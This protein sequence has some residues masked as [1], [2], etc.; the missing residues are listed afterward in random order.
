M[1][2]ARYREPLNQLNL[3]TEDTGGFV[4]MDN[5]EI[6]RGFRRIVAEN[7]A[8]YLLAYYASHRRDDK[9]HRINVRV[10]RPRVTVQAR[11]GYMS[12]GPRAAPAARR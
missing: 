11:R 7:S 3:L 4:V 12:A 1:A 2:L 10:K 5:N 8:Y 9:F 6:D